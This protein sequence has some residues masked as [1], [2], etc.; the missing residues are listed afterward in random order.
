ME[1]LK[2]DELENVSGGTQQGS[3]CRCNYCNSTFS[4]Y[5]IMKHL[6]LAHGIKDVD[7]TR[8]YEQI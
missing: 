4:P 1:E 8:D 5:F 7:P 3:G 2:I 6:E